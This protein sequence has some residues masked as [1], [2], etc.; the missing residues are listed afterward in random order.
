MKRY[1]E[2]P[3][4]IYGN[5]IYGNLLN[6]E[7]IDF[8]GNRDVPVFVDRIGITHPDKDYFVKRKHSNYITLEYVESGKGYVEMDNL[9][10]E[11][12]AGDVYLLLPGSAHKYWADE[13]NPFKKLW[14]NVYSELLLDVIHHLGLNNQ[15][16]FHGG[17]SFKPMFESLFEIGNRTNVNDFVYSDI[18]KVIFNILMDLT[19]VKDKRFTGD[20]IASYTRAFLNN[21]IYNNPTVKGMAKRL[22][23]TETHLIRCFKQQY[24]VTPRQYLINKKISIA[25]SMLLNSTMTIGEIAKLLSFEN[26]HYFS[27]LFGKKVGLTPSQY[28]AEEK[29]KII[30]DTTK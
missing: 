11:V 22:F 10:H 27:T 8:F 14:I 28:R 2:N 23:V 20:N 17:E 16:V 18:C 9:I 30:K 25:K 6:E 15:P 1:K 5:Y 24:G 4:D 7:F 29:N 26:E 13:K 19:D 12:T 21:Q 3:S